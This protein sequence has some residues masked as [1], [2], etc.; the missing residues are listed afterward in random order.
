MLASLKG[1][2]FLYREQIEC[3]FTSFRS[4]WS[5]MA[6]QHHS[7][8]QNLRHWF[9]G[10]TVHVRAGRT[11]RGRSATDHVRAVVT[12]LGAVDLR[13]MVRRSSKVWLYAAIPPEKYETQ[14]YWRRNSSC[15]GSAGNTAAGTQCRAGSTSG[16]I[17]RTVCIG[18]TH[19][20]TSHANA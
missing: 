2:P 16:V 1:N 20:Y 18:R 4:L 15:K 13:A 7:H 3:I 12:V 6:H 9:A 19:R 8:N 5:A 17:C 11:K 10:S 14:I